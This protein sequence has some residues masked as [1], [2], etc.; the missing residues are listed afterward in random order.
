MYSLYYLAIG[1]NGLEII[2]Y[3]VYFAYFCLNK[4]LGFDKDNKYKVIIFNT[5]NRRIIP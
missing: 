5:G 1:V 3:G 4:L 2:I